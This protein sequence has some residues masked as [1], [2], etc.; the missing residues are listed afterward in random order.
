[1]R[2][3]VDCLEQEEKFELGMEARDALERLLVAL[4]HQ[5]EDLA[6]LEPIHGEGEEKNTKM[7]KNNNKKE[8]K[9]KRQQ[10]RQ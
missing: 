2:V 6:L 3:F 7:K 9:R 1:M 5:A 8:K 4:P 10:Q